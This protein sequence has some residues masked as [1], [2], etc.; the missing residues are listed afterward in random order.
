MLKV[1]KW[2]ESHFDNLCGSD[3]CVKD[4]PCLDTMQ[5][6]AIQK[7]K[8]GRQFMVAAIEAISTKYQNET[9]AG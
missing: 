6:E 9:K 5:T 1:T 7:L 8:D 2:I 3:S 4:K